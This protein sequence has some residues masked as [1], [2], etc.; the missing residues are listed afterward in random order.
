MALIS[1]QEKQSV[2]RFALFDIGFRP[3][4][5]G[6][7]LFALITMGLWH[8]LFNHGWSA[9]ALQAS[10]VIWHAH[11]MIYGY[12]LA[13]IAG[14][15]LTAVQ[16]WTGIKTLKGGSLI[17]LILIW[18]TGRIGFWLADSIPLMLLAAIDNL[19][20]LYLMVA[21]ARPIISIRQWRQLPI[22]IILILFLTGNIAFYAGLT[23]SLANGIHIGLYGGFYL[24]LLLMLI[25]S[26]RVMPMFITNGVADLQAAIKLTNR[27]WMDLSIIILFIAYALLD[28]FAGNNL[29][30]SLLAV[31]LALLNGIRL[32]GWHVASIWKKPLL[33]VLYVAHI[34]LI[35]GF[36]LKAASPVFNFSPMLAV[37]AFSVGGIGMLTLG[38]M[39]RVSLGHTGR[40]VFNPPINLNP[41][42]MC[43]AAAA[44]TR[45]IFPILWEHQYSLWIGISQAFWCLAFAL[46]LWRY[47]A[48]LFRPRISPE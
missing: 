4:F 45:V 38:M 28:I 10:P 16:N 1:L 32:A 48:I 12:S 14:F 17:L 20:I 36:A 37:H 22:L 27:P 31:I 8:L 33:W 29:L 18:L 43:M 9:G 2:N 44:V 41:L 11:E 26:R 30:A 34:W 19:F 7:A 40:N 13:V 39:S 24:I 47:T 35:I 6:A 25:I 23:G 15:L 42:F 46:F 5:F 21:I 3:F